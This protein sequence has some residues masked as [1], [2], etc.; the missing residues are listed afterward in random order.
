MTWILIIVF[1]SGVN[2]APLLIDNIASREEC[3]KLEE[4]IHKEPL[5]PFIR[6]MCVSVRKK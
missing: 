3:L 2:T 5:A 6:S 1:S 4:T